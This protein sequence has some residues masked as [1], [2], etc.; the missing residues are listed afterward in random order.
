MLRMRALS[1]TAAVCAAAVFAWAGAP[2]ISARQFQTQAPQRDAAAGAPPQMRA[3][4]VGTASITGTVTTSDGRPVRDARVQINGAANAPE[5]AAIGTGSGAAS[6]SSGITVI[7]GRGGTPVS[8]GGPMPGG[9][10]SLSRS[11]VTDASGRFS[12]AKLPA[13][14]FTLNASKNNFL[15]TNFGQK[16]AGAPGSTIIVAD[17]QQVTAN[18][19]LM[20]GGVITGTVFGTDGEPMGRIQI[21]AWRYTT[22][23]GVRRLSQ[24][25]GTST[26]D[27]G[28]YRISNLQPGD[29]LISATPNASDAQMAA[30][31]NP[32]AAAIEEAIASGKVQPPSAPG[33]P[34]TVLVPMPQRPAGPVFNEMPG[35]LPTYHP[36]TPMSS[37]AQ[38]IHV[39]GGDEHVA[40]VTVQYTEGG[41]I[42]G[43]ISPPVKPGM[44]LRVSLVNNDPSIESMNGTSINQNG[45]FTFRSLAP[46]TYTVMAQTIPQQQPGNITV[47]SGNTTTTSLAPPPQVPAEDRLWGAATATVTGGQP[48]AVTITLQK[49]RSIS[50]VVVFD[51]A[52][53]PDLTRSRMTVSL[54]TVGP[55]MAMSFGPQPQAVLEAD[56]RFT[57]A[58]VPPGR[59]SIR[60]NA[61]GPMKSSIVGGVDTLDFPLEFTA[62]ED[63]SD[64]VL[65]VTDKFSE[66][67]GTLTES[68]GKPGVDYTVIAAAAD[69]KFWTPNSRRIAST[70]T[71]AEGKYL[72]RSLPPGEY[73]VVV[74]S[75]FEQGMQYDP[76]FLK[77][78]ASAGTRVRIT[79]GG[80]TLQDLRVR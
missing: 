50:G 18:V 27:R 28:I 53:P 15:P 34:S 35:Y 66:L 74:L 68:T 76:D 41:S 79:D 19:T 1:V 31:M 80:K 38:V 39:T 12:F 61:G 60:T 56:G 33:F 71:G 26:D 44:Q 51:M 55:P 45:Q 65:T 73:Y 72:F 49:G 52:R 70:R 43:T 16:R 8:S 54:A 37:N 13:G 6:Q 30:R 63:I 48:T 58:G 5:G 4:P 20:R 67:S 69:E 25:N 9:G 7:S 22:T 23:S 78:L 32:D 21:G 77:S 47:V 57:I 40:D 75:D 17:G 36:G 46:G 42:T 64:A 29:Y 24:N 3:I 62:T 2:G 59:Y 10:L 14:H 11:A